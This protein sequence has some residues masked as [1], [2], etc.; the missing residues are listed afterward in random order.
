MGSD[1]GD[2]STLGSVR[3][4]IEEPATD[5]LTSEKDMAYRVEILEGDEVFP[6]DEPIY[7]KEG[8]ADPAHISSRISRAKL[9]TRLRVIPVDAAGNEGP[10]SNTITIGFDESGACALLSARPAGTL[11]P[12][13]CLLLWV[14]LRG[15]RRTKQ[16]HSA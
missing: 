7:A 1:P 15:R 5:D 8:G 11:L 3:I 12:T 10:P 13:A 16:R 9:R 4:Q 14:A 6:T 2:C